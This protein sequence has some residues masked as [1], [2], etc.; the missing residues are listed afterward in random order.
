MQPPFG[1]PQGQQPGGPR[2]LGA[3]IPAP[4]P[5]IPTTSLPG[6]NPQ[7][8]AER[9]RKATKGFGTDE[10]TVINTLA[11]LDPFQIDILAR[12]YEQTT[13]RT[14]KKT[15]ESELSRW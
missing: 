7:F 3:L 11:P 13:G 6:Y 10:T 15:L 12:V 4:P 14:L 5:A 2:F 8:D 1:G 9:I